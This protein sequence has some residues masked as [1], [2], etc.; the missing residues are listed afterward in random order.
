MHASKNKLRNV[1]ETKKAINYSNLSSL[2]ASHCKDEAPS[3]ELDR[4][5]CV[6]VSEFNTPTDF[7]IKTNLRAFNLY[8]QTFFYDFF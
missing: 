3:I 2:R 7:V 1:R 5:R 4:T 8:C 6:F